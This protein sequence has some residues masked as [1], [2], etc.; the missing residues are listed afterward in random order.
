MD[1]IIQEHFTICQLI[2]WWYTL[3]SLLGSILQRFSLDKF[4]LQIINKYIFPSSTIRNK[5][6]NMAIT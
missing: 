5:E 6:F 2:S 4:F 1:L 3:S